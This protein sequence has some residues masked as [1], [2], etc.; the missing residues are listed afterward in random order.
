MLSKIQVK[1]IIE[2]FDYEPLLVHKDTS[3][4]EVAKDLIIHPVN[5][6]VYVV[7][8]E[9]YLLGSIVILQV[10][11][12]IFPESFNRDNLFTID[13]DM[14]D[15]Y[16]AKT[17]GDMMHETGDDFVTNND[18]VP[19]VFYKMKNNRVT[20]LPIVDSDRKVIGVIHIEHI[21]KCW[22]QRSYGY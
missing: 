22:Y 13:M 10:M 7:D 15:A 19:D 8:D 18:Y 11:E 21:L 6:N 9:N 2:I 1:D 17:A 14:V 20:Q 12:K 16:L 3:V 4:K 5:R